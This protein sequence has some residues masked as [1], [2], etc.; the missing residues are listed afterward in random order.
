MLPNRCHHQRDQYRRGNGF[1]EDEDLTLLFE[2][3]VFL[4]QYLGDHYVQDRDKAGPLQQ[5]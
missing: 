4:G 2:V 1:F 5:N 3:V